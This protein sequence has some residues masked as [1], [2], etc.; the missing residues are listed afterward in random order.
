MKNA[1][2]KDYLDDITLFSAS[3]EE[4]Q[5]ML[6]LRLKA[7]EKCEELDLPKIERVKIHRWPLMNV[8]N[9]N[10]E[11]LG[12]PV[13]PIFD[14]MEDNPMIIQGRTTT[15]YE[16]MP[17]ELSEQGVIFT[18]IFTAMKEHSELV[19]EYFMTKA[20]PMDE[21]K[22]TAFHTA[23]LN[24]GVFLYVPK[25]VVVKEAFESL[26]FQS[27]TDNSAWI[28]HVLIVAEENS[29][30]TYLERLHTEGEGSEK[31]SAN[32]VVEVIAKPGSKVKFAAID[33]LGENV[34]TYMNRRAHVMRDAS[35]DWALG[36]MNDGDVIADFDSDLAGVGSH[37]EVKVVAISSGRQVQG[38][39][40]RVTNMAP[41]SVG[42][43]LQHGVIRERG[44]LTFNGIGHILKGAKGAD[45]QQES[46][47]LMLS[48]KARG[49]ANPILLI[50]EF[51]VTAGHAASAGRLDP[52]ELYYLM[53]RGIPQKEAERLVTRGFLGSVIT[54]IPVKAV[55]DEFVEVIDRKLVD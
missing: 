34:S 32:F 40:T 21:D 51:E 24:G 3:Q 17:V 8:G 27:M 4:P 15:L 45:A 46:R 29:E 14:E 36:I 48:D 13:L 41:H 33:R 47:V 42:N 11:I 53:S 18:D 55:Q 12:N 52:E 26:F 54:A 10:E 35:V 16:Q 1:D 22:M 23:F 50:D 39:D 20:V 31:I 7:L 49:D 30:V 38:I 9:L 28:K 37:S 25:N 5:W 44:T 19:E 43:I 6:D 2:L